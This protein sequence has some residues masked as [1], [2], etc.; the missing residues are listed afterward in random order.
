MRM[1][2]QLYY[3]IQPGGS[4]TFSRDS[5]TL[6]INSC[7]KRTWIIKFPGPTITSRLYKTCPS[8]QERGIFNLLNKR[9]PWKFSCWANCSARSDENS[10]SPSKIG[11]LLLCAWRP[12]VFSFI[13]GQISV[14][15]YWHADLSLTP[16]MIDTALA[17]AD[18][19]NKCA[20]RPAFP[21]SAVSQSKCSYGGQEIISLPR[22]SCLQDFFT[23]QSDFP[24]YRR[25][26]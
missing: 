3:L 26:V 14:K 22:Q 13:G 11:A 20:R 12:S 25:D 21:K 18:V 17:V 1:N 9:A 23:R 15:E 7:K 2:G 8:K 5:C 6:A 24:R 10:T 19:E 4:N 16:P